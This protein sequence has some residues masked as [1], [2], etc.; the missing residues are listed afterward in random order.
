MRFDACV[1]YGLMSVA[2]MGFGG[3]MADDIDDILGD[4]AA[5]PSSPDATASTINKPNFTVSFL[6]P[7]Y[8]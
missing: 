4:A 8:S 7:S 1:A 2:L 6:S 5:A 3:V